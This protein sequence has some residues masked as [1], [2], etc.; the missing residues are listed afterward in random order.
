MD[1]ASV[2]YMTWKRSI[3]AERPVLKFQKLR[4]GAYLPAYHSTHAAGFDFHAMVP[5]DESQ[6]PGMEYVLPMSKCII[7]TGLAA[8]IPQGYEI[9]VR[10]RSGLAFKHGITIIN[11]PGTIDSD[12]FDEIKIVLF[13]LGTEGFKVFNGDRIAQGVL[14]PVEQYSIEEVKEFSEE[15]L[16]DNRGGGYGS[17]G[18]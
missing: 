4:L 14:K 12:F 9:Q 8:L 2:E 13:N 16:K 17:T 6:R 11:S 5:V 15:D 18:I 7:H 10:P 3:V 1:S